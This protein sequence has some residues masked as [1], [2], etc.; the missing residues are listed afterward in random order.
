MIVALVPARNA[1][2][3][4]PEYLAQ[5]GRWCDALVALDDGS[6]DATRAILDAHPLVACVL[7]NPRR[8]DFGGWHDGRNRNRLLHAAAALRPHWIVS[9]DTDER[10]DA[11]DADALRDLVAND[12]VPGCAY[13]FRHYRMWGAGDHDPAFGIIWR[14]F[15][16]RDGLAFPNEALHFDPVPTAIP[17]GARVPTTIRVRHY[18][19]ATADRVT[20]RRRK[21]R[22]A[23]PGGRFRTDFGRLTDVAHAPLAR[24]RPRPA[25]PPAL[26]PDALSPTPHDSAPAGAPRVVCLLPVR[27]GA[28]DLPGWFASARRV[29]DA[30]VALDDGSTDATRALLDAEP[31]VARVLTNPARP[32]YAGWNDA[33]NRQRLLDAAGDLR[34]DWILQLDADERI[35]ANDAAALRRFL[36]DGAEPGTAYG[37]R[38]FRM[39]D[40]LDHY[41][42]AG[43]W[44]YRVFAYRPGQALP[45]DRLHLVPVPTSIPQDRRRKTSIRIQHVG[46]STDQRRRDRAA[47]YREADPDHAFQ[48]GYDHLL[49]APGV[50]RPWAARPPDFPVLMDAAGDDVDL[51]ALDLDGPVLTVIVIAR[52]DAA[53]VADRV[54]SVVEQHCDAPTETIVVTSGNDRTA[55]I[56]RE[57]FPQVRVIRLDGAALP[58]RARNAGLRLARGDYVSFPGSH[59]ELPPGSLAARVRAHEAGHALVTGSMLNGTRT[60][61]GWASYF[62]DHSAALPGRPCALLEGPPG[63]CSYARDFLLEVGGFPEDMRAG[64]DTVVNMELWRRGHRAWR[65]AEVT[66]IHHSP[67]RTAARLIRH[68]FLRGR[69]LGRIMRHRG[70]AARA[71]VGYLPRRLATT[72]GNVQRRADPETAREYRRAWPLVV[73]GALSALAGA[74]WELVAGP[75]SET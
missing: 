23:D 10:L 29:A 52:D 67:C 3:D 44:A 60:R 25:G 6:T 75:R 37:M 54:R 43:L 55:D 66:L 61:A 33:E 62:L 56:V 38:V 28:H 45:T 8:P 7:S 70:D 31:L 19:A 35:D 51:H 59:V 53:T 30:V 69:G 4:L 20:A 5:A 42:A 40:G 73:V 47:K 15:A 57:S 16:Y 36:R 41:D 48:S 50:R 63:S 64:E 11:D 18:G 65:Q 34:P 58:G 17:H 74:T 1:E 49:A 72:A 12:A 46:S 68:H 39:L 22:E 9:I 14:L 27:N 13:G 24:W 26:S 71:L 32:S 21:Y 2:A